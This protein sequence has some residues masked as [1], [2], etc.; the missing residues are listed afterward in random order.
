[1]DFIIRWRLFR[2]FVVIDRYP[3]RDIVLS[4][5]FAEFDNFI[6]LLTLDFSKRGIKHPIQILFTCFAYKGKQS[7]PNFNLGE[8]MGN[9]S[10]SIERDGRYTPSFST[11]ALIVEEKWQQYFDEILDR[12]TQLKTSRADIASFFETPHKPDWWQNDQTP[13]NSKGIKYKFIGQFNLEN[14]FPGWDVMIFVFYD[15]YDSKVSY[16]HQ[17]D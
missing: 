4:H 3:N 14:I 12:Y 11:Q 16:I 7:D 17:L 6:P 10:F 13:V 5:P 2:K 9:F 1:M 8:S 15:K